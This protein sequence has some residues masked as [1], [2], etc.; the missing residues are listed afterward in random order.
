MRNNPS[1]IAEGEQAREAGFEFNDSEGEGELM[2]HRVGWRDLA[3]SL[4]LAVVLLPSYMLVAAQP[5][6]ANYTGGACDSIPKYYCISVWYVDNGS[7]VTIQERWNQGGVDGGAQEW[8]RYITSDWRRDPLTGA[9]TI[10]SS[11]SAGAWRTNVP[12]DTYDNV[13]SYHDVENEAW[14]QMRTR[15]HEFVPGT[16]WYFWCGDGIDWHLTGGVGPSRWTGP[17]E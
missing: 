13:V 8:Q 17:C 14:V 1:S 3:R 6:L 10:L 11:L 15:F 9:W 12:L 5:A 7:Y 16:G 4:V 2:A